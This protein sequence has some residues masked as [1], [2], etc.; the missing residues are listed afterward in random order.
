[1]ALADVFAGAAERCALVNGH[2]VAHNGGLADD[3][4]HAV[5]D[6]HALANDRAGVDLNAGK[7]PGKL[8]N[9]AGKEL[10]MM[11]VE[12]MGRAVHKD[13]PKTRVAKNDLQRVSCSRVAGEDSLDL[14]AN[15][16]EHACFSHLIQNKS[17]PTHRGVADAVPL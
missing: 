17:P 7:M 9:D 6:E 10:A 5:V 13:R 14:T 4:A 11:M 1:M 8:R 12:P 16:F 15:G 2:I 3:H